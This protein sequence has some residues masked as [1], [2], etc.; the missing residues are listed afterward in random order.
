MSIALEAYTGEGL[1]TGV[2][3]ADGRL[4]DLIAGVSTLVLRDAVV[5]PFAG[6]PE[7]APG[8]SGVEVDDLMA[9][10][11]A[12][13]TFV[14]FHPAWHPIAVDAGPYRL[15]GELP[16][17]PGFDPTRALARST[18]AFILLG[19]V[20]VE[21]RFEGSAAGLNEHPCVWVNR[22]A[23]DAVE[24]ELQLGFFFPGALDVRARH[25]LAG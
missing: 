13:H 23:V 25:A 11:A 12:P 14:P 22:Y 17:L 10:V 15:R 4:A 2:V 6:P 7:S 19:R 9:I 16:S 21:L 3:V 18:G 20:T 1:L 8:L 5:T 24:S